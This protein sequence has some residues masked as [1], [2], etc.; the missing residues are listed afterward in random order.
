MREEDWLFFHVTMEVDSLIQREN[1]SSFVA[2]Y[3]T[4]IGLLGG[5]TWSTTGSLTTIFIQVY[6]SCDCYLVFHIQVLHYIGPV[7]TLSLQ[8]CQLTLSGHSQVVLFQLQRHWLCKAHSVLA[9]EADLIPFSDL[10]VDY[11]QMVHWKYFWDASKRSP[12][13]TS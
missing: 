7:Y 8:N 3:K 1:Q 10:K 2:R 12:C 11:I 13:K 5:F 6:W 4:I 9:R